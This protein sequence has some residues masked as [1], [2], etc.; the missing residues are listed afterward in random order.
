MKFVI[1]TEELNRLLKK[2]QNVVA[3]NKSIPILSNFLMEV[4]NSMLT[5]TAT[6]LTVGM[7]C[8]TPV[9]VLQGGGTTLPARHL[10]RLV[11]ELTVGNIEVGTDSNESSEIVAGSSRFKLKGLARSAFP[12]LPDLAGAAQ[13]R[14]SEQVLYDLFYRTAFAVSRE[15]NR[16]VLTGVLLKIS[17]GRVMFVGTDGKRLAKAEV[18]IDIDPGLEGAYIIPLKAVEEMLKGLSQDAEALA[19]VYLMSDKVAVEAQGTLVI[20]KLLNGDYPDVERVIPQGANATLSLHREELMTLLRQISLFTTETTNSVRFTFA[21]GDLVLSA[22][23]MDLGEGRVS[24]P[25]NYK[26]PRLDIAFHPGYFLD[27]LRH[28]RGEIVE[29]QLTDSYNPGKLRDGEDTTALFVIMPMRLN[30]Q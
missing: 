1:A 13:F 26:G 5:L 4:D 9:K 19:T 10:Q 11:N 14:I 2:L 22:N 27:I 8:Q 16:Y 12:E 25:V 29:L 30:E 6:D 28:C 20:S 7:R 21:D 15:D 3:Q 17:N 23:S 24:M 18:E